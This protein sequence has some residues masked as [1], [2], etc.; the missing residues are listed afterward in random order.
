MAVSNYVK[1]AGFA[2][3]AAVILFIAVGPTAGNFRA[4]LSL[5]FE[6]VAAVAWPL[7]T[8]LIV[9][10]L[11][12]PLGDLAGRGMGPVQSSPTALSQ[13][14]TERKKTDASFTASKP[15]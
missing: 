6:F 9:L 5:V 1:I 8:V 2:A 13:E 15:D 7:A 11:R 12:K 14:A 3:V 10:I 4:L